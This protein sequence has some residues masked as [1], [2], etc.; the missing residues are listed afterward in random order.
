MSLRSLL[1]ANRGEIAVRIIRAASELGMRA[2][3]VYS[4]D[5]E[6]ALHTRK[7]DQAVALQGQGA[8]AYLDIDQLA[9]AA[10]DTGCDA[11]HPGYGFLSESAEFARRCAEQGITFVG[12][13]PETLELFGDKARAR[14]MAESCLVPVLPGT[15]GATSL[16]EAREF[17]E[18][19]G[20]APMMIKALAGGGGRGMRAVS[21]VEEIES[22]YERSR[23]EA[24]KAFGVGD[25]YVERLVREARHIEVQIVGDGSGAVIHLGEREC[26]IQRRHQKL[27]EIAPAPGLAEAMREELCGAAVRLA[28]QVSY[29]NLGTF[30]FLV[31]RAAGAGGESAFSFIE[32]NARLQ[33]EHT[34]T[35]EVTGVDLVQLQLRLAGGSSLDQL[36]IDSAAKPG[37]HALQ[38]RVNMERMSADGAARPSGGTLTTFEPP[39]GEGIRTDSHG[40]AGYS[41]SPRFDSLLAKLIVHEKSDGH[42]PSD[43]LEGVIDRTRDA[44]ARFKIEGRRDERCVPAK[45][46]GSSRISG[47]PLVHALYRGSYRGFGDRRSTERFGAPRAG[48]GPR[49]GGSSGGRFRPVGRA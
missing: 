22:A 36:G 31:D 38:V 20:G 47:R 6:S 11:I 19:L 24:V 39:R 13:R 3:A 12:P 26:S 4:E 10:G 45:R 27:V 29:Q 25:V 7:A 5:D 33:V 34:V 28:E 30:E 21:R 17:F 41:T 37:G 35:E 40:Y 49:D 42:E 16:D 46:V 23:S 48:R 2:V 1:I 18:S 44:L 43:G 9:A 15:S 14:A 8:R 32:A